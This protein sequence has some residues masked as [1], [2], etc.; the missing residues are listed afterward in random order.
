MS[1]PEA[2]F[3]TMPRG[4]TKDGR[5]TQPEDAPRLVYDSLG[6]RHVGLLQDGAERYWR[7][8]CC[9]PTYRS[10]EAVERQL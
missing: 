1:F 5:L 7:E 3:T 9:D 10:V 2:G 8:G 6:I 4:P